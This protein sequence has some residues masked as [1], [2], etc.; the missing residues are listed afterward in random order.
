[1]ESKNKHN[2]KLAF[3]FQIGNS[4]RDVFYS[5]IS[6]EDLYLKE[7]LSKVSQSNF[8]FICLN[9]NLD[10]RSPTSKDLRKIVNSF[11]N[12]LFPAPSSFEMKDGKFNEKLYIEELSKK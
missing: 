8:K 7:N 10:Y 3:K 2:N 9:D 1:M 6:N 12:S 11:Y 4:T 5:S